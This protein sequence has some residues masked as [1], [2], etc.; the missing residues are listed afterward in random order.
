MKGMVFGSLT[1]ISQAESRRGQRYWL[2]RC[3]C[4]KEKEI[5][6][7]ALR[8]GHTKSCG[9]KQMGGMIGRGGR[10]KVNDLTGL[11]FGLLSVVNRDESKNKHQAYWK[12]KCDCGNETIVRGGLLTSGNNKSCGCNQSPYIKDI[13]GQRFGLLVAVER[14][15]E[16]SD[17]GSLTW[18]CR[19]DCGKTRDV[20]VNYLVQGRTKSCGCLR[21]GNSGVKKPK[22]LKGMVFGKLTAAEMLPN[23]TASGGVKWLCNCDCGKT[24]EVAQANLKSGNTKSCGCGRRKKKSHL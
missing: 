18:H 19:C 11:R 12:C 4:G 21:K 22:V 8:S 20:P 1:V 6:A 7:T 16:K 24:V 3:E 17:N 15:G 5:R 14:T 9:C 13:T 10:G 2:C 23:R